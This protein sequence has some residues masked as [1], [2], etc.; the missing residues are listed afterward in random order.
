MIEP[1][2]AQMAT[3]F[4]IQDEQGFNQVYSAV[5][6]A[7][8]RKNRR[9]DWIIDKMRAANARHALEIGC[10]TGETADYIA[11]HV[12]ARVTALDISPSFIDQ[13]RQHYQQPNL[14]FEVLDFLDPKTV[15]PRDVDFVFGNGILH[16][17]VKQLPEVLVRLRALV[18]PGGTLAFIEPNLLNPFCAFIF[19]TP[20]GRR[21]AR[22]DPDEMAFS[23][24]H[25]RRLLAEAGWH[26]ISVST[27]D[28]LIP[29]LPASWSGPI[30]R[31]EPTLEATRLTSW[32]AQ[33]NFIVARA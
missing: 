7:V 16:H 3:K 11:R 30:K 19:G 8:E 5:G 33:S 13:A 20:P 9:N 28:F 12:T 14:T 18:G 23:A 25:I 26:D 32:L 21:W 22:L 29:G 6:S 1:V 2:R 24:G 27:R 17:L 4:T 31:V 15:I 10:G